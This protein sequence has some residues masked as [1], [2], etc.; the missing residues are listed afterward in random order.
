MEPEIGS[1]SQM[2]VSSEPGGPWANWGPRLS[3]ESGEYVHL[4]GG[5]RARTLERYRKK[6]N[7]REWAEIVFL[8]FCHTSGLLDTQI[9]R[10]GSSLLCRLL[11]KDVHNRARIKAGLP[12]E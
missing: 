7:L 3:P 9:S 10:V 6:H 8:L 4:P 12:L 1:T 5:S 11:S 2:Q